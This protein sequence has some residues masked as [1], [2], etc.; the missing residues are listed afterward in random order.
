MAGLGWQGKSLLLVTPLYGARVRLAT[1]LTEAP[2]ET[3][4]PIKNQCGECTRCRDAC[5]AEAIKGAG[6]EEN[7]GSRSEALDLSRCVDK[8]A[9]E[10]AKIP[11]V[12]AAI[13]G[14]CIK[15]CPFGRKAR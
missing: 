3:D 15:V 8:T 6:T 11:E 5:P 9:G 1:V 12:G 13:C 2:L 14:I 4:S 7:Y 10:F